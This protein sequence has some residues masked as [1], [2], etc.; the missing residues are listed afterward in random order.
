MIFELT[1][2]EATLLE[3]VAMPQITRKTIALTYAYA[4]RSSVPVDFAKVNRA[5]IERWSFSGLEYIKQ[6]AWKRFEKE[7]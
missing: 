4:M 6:L 5:I 7:K 1:N 2:P 3:E